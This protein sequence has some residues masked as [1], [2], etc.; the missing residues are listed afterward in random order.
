MNKKQLTEKY[1]KILNESFLDTAQ[2][3]LD[4]ADLADPTP[5]TSGINTAISLGRYFTSDDEAERKEQLV[6]ASLR[7]LGVLPVFGDFAKAGIYGSKIGKIATNPTVSKIATNPLVT[8]LLKTASNIPKAR[9]AS[10]SYLN[11]QDLDTIRQ[12]LKSN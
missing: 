9:V 6:N 12:G 8:N 5:I 4:V 10:K 1:Y 11:P 2:T 7:A 3:V